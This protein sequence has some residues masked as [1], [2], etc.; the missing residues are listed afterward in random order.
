MQ[1][2]KQSDEIF[3]T[4]GSE[5][6]LNDISCRLISHFSQAQLSRRSRTVSLTAN[7]NVL[8]DTA[9]SI[10]QSRHYDRYFFD[11]Q[12]LPGY[13][14][15]ANYNGMQVETFPEVLALRDR[16][17][18]ATRHLFAADYVEFRLL[19]GV[20]CTMAMVAALTRPNDVVLSICPHSGGHFATA[21]IVQ[22]LGRH[23]EK[24]KL[25]SAGGPD[26]DG[27]ESIIRRFGNRISA[28]IFDHGMTTHPIPVA[29][30]RRKLDELGLHLTLILYDASHVLGLIAGNGFP[31][32]LDE[33]A[34]VLQG[35]THKSFAGPH[36]ALVVSRNPRIAER[37][38]SEVSAGL[39]SSPQLPSLLQLFVTIL[40]MEKYAAAYS[41]KMI[42]NAALLATCLDHL[43]LLNIPPTG[44]HIVL[45]E[46]ESV[47]AIATKLNEAG[48]RVNDKKLTSKSYLRLGVQEVTRLGID[49]DGIQMLGQI[50]RDLIM[51][52][53]E[54]KIASRLELVSSTLTHVGYSFDREL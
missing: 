32:P 4:V 3:P 31:N 21:H 27:F 52:Q 15:A 37:I 7:E 48:I 5:K 35:N 6:Y 20:H 39:V 41:K 54:D 50:I 10:G 47:S 23:H 14:Y 38:N 12:V 8:S 26:L 44:T 19:S 9:R 17:E 53:R 51:G 29:P 16:A 1:L 11:C 43:P 2:F 42:G 49:D 40:E 28:V 36:R 18:S 22:K 13:R 30:V 46:G 24:F 34:D 45:L 33:G 25:T